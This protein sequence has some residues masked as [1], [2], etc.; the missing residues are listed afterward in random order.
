MQIECAHCGK[1]ADKPASAVN[2]ARRDGLNIYCSRACSGLA[3]RKWKSQ[4]QRKVEKAE[5]DRGYRAKNH[6]RRAAQKAEYHQRTYDP[7]KQREYNQSRMRPHIEYCRRPEYRE[8]KRAYDRHY[9]AEK[10]YGPLAECFL[11]TLDIRDE[12]L[13]Q[14]SD[15]EIRRSKGTFGKSQQRK[16]DYER[17]DRKEPEIGPMGNSQLRA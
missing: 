7:Q 17:L 12:C 14:Q 11:L 6:A 4:A 9:R 1:A 15:Y 2:R 13:A 8:K 5:Y 10:H 3:R 16:R